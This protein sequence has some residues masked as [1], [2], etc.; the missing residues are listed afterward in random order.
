M[1]R[2]T[3]Y[4]ETLA[5][6]ICGRLIEGRSLRS[7]CRDED[8]PSTT[9]VFSWLSKYHEFAAQYA[10]ACE[11]RADADHE[12]IR[13]IAD[14]PIM[15]EEITEGPDGTTIK[16]GDAIAHRRLQVDVRKW[17]MARMQPRKYGDRQHVEH[18][19]KVGLESLVAGDEKPGE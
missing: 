11:L 8:M 6:E 18:S 3:D 14:T 19:G 17:S 13:E 10:R 7:V 5:T 15:G 2:P 4:N 9:A 16:R 12:E 1:G